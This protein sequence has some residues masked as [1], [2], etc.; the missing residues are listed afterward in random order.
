MCTDA[1]SHPEA[2]NLEAPWPHR[3]RGPRVLNTGGRV[4]P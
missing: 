2:M 4:C 3:L 1:R